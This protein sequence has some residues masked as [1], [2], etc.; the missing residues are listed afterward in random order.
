MT[1]PVVPRL[2]SA[3]VAFALLSLGVPAVAQDIPTVLPKG[4]EMSDV[5][6]KQRIRATIN[7]PPATVQS[8]PRDVPQNAELARPAGAALTAT[9]YRPSPEVSARVRQQFAEWLAKEADKQADHLIISEVLA[10]RDPVLD[11]AQIVE[12]YGLRPGDMAD[13]MASYWILNWSMANRG[14]SGRVQA[15]AVRNQVRWMINPSY[16]RLGGAARQEISELLILNFLIQ[17][18]AYTDAVKRGDQDAVT[19]LSDAAVDRFISEMGVDLRRLLLTDAGFVR[20][21]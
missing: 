9:T 19:K 21:G 10:E 5:V 1:L 12:G 6:N 7:T 2:A 4:Y 11:W 15:E 3:L 14:E 18:A 17:H 8:V 20:G 16:V 13:A